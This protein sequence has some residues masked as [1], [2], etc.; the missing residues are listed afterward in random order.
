MIGT[1]HSE[2]RPRWQ[3]SASEKRIQTRPSAAST[4]FGSFT[5]KLRSTRS[6][7]IS[8]TSPASSVPL[9]NS[10]FSILEITCLGIQIDSLPQP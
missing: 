7:L 6:R 9:A 5:A 2:A 3:H 8:G 1:G 4:M 10:W